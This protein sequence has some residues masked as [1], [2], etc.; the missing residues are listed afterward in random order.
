[1]LLPGRPLHGQGQGH[2]EGVGQCHCDQENGDLGTGEVGARTPKLEQM[3]KLRSAAN[4]ESPALHQA[5]WRREGLLATARPKVAMRPWELLHSS[6]RALLA[7]AWGWAE[8]PES[9]RESGAV[10]Q[11]RRVRLPPQ[12][13]KEAS[14][15]AV[16]KVVE[17]AESRSSST[18]LLCDLGAE[19]WVGK[20]G[21]W[22]HGECPC[23]SPRL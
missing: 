6:S 5:G 7:P 16:R 20:P 1:M 4:P 12:P 2:G 10:C 13:R 9:Q 18:R 3:G 22:D 11:N 14:G 15:S 23:S 21:G 19:T 17:G 8:Q